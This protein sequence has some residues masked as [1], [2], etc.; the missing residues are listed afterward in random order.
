MG[1]AVA[2]GV[3]VQEAVEVRDASGVDV[4]ELM[5]VEVPV[6]IEVEEGV[7]VAVASTVVVG[8]LV[9]SPSSVGVGVSQGAGPAA[10]FCTTGKKYDR[11]KLTVKA[12]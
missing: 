3:S 12:L 2:A 9:T 5:G 8:G 1:D 10:P 6:L 11:L 4:A 7:A